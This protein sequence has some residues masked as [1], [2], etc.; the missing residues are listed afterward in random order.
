[1]TGFWRLLPSALALALALLALPPPLGLLGVAES[2]PPTPR[3]QVSEE[4]E[5]VFDWSEEACEPMQYPDLPARVFRDYRG[6]TQ[7]LLSHFD[8]FR[9]VGPSLDRLS[10][11]CDPVMLSGRSPSARRFDDREWIGSLFTRDGRTIWALVHDEYQGHRHRG[12]CPGG[13]YFDCWYNAITLARSVDGGRSYQ[14]ARPPRHLVAAVPHRYR[15]GRGPTGVF[16]PSNIVRG[17]G[18]L[19]YALVRLR[20]PSGVRGTCVMR[21]R[22]IGDPHSWRAWDG[23]GFH[24]AFTDPYA[25]RSRHGPPCA[26]VET[27]RIAEMAESLT[28]NTVLGEYLLVGLAPPGEETIGPQLTGIY[29]STSPDLLHWSARKLVRAAP[30]LNSYRCGDHSPIAYPSLVDPES[31]SRTFAT[32]GAHPYLY[33]TQFRYRDCRQTPERDLIRVAVEISP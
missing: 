4:R 16:T 30:T 12:H 29:F 23:T 18:G 5:I 17:P 21:T 31:R 1:M 26:P 32:T 7:L 10:L 20:D 19:L 9:M 28:Y 13:G 24:G 6:R 22:R 3:V 33:F 27:G 14:H 15:P 8:N 11:D 25:A 2:A